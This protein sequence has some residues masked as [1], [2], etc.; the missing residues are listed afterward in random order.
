[1]PAPPTA[2]NDSPLAVLFDPNAYRIH[3]TAAIRFSVAGLV[4]EMK[5]RQTVAAVIPVAFAIKR[6]IHFPTAY[7]TL[8]AVAAGVVFV[9]AF[10]KQLPLILS[11]QC[12][13]LLKSKIFVLLEVMRESYLLQTSRPETVFVSVAL[14]TKHTPSI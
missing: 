9:I 13:N 5:T 7:L 11:V 12:K 6:R 14:I 8:K 1:M 10:L 3:D 2:M 4:I